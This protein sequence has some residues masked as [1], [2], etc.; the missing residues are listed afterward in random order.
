MVF[1]EY[2]WLDLADKL[3]MTGVVG[4]PNETRVS[5][6]SK[7]QEISL[8]YSMSNMFWQ[9]GVCGLSFGC[10]TNDGFTIY[11]NN[12][13][14]SIPLVYNDVAAISKANAKL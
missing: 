11:L 2:G 13:E 3:S 7:W 8:N 14:E 12:T 9:L 4:N 5:V 1:E 10:S 6:M